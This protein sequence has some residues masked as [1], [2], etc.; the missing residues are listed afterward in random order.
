MKQAALLHLAAA[1]ARR[2][3]RPTSSS[4]EADQRR[5][6]PPDKLII[7]SSR[8]RIVSRS[9]APPTRCARHGVE[10][11]VPHK[12]DAGR[13]SV[14]H[15][16][17]SRPAR[18]T[19]SGR[20]SRRMSII[21]RG[22][23]WQSTVRWTI[24]ASKPARRW[25]DSCCGSH[26]R[27]RAPDLSHFDASTATPRCATTGQYV[28]RDGPHRCD[29][30]ASWGVGLVV[31]A[32]PGADT[33]TAWLPGASRRRLGGQPLAVERDMLTA[34][35]PGLAP[36]LRRRC[37]CTASERRQ[38]SLVAVVERLSREL[39]R[40]VRSLPRSRGARH[41]LALLGADAGTAL[42]ALAPDPSGLWL[43]RPGVTP[44]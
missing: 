22:V 1:G 31:D 17:C 7:T 2:P 15:P 11:L 16:P 37:G 33:T 8:R 6:R 4:P 12:G 38:S 32:R 29:H 5:R 35:S 43:A 3:C 24:G 13:P 40:R 36:L 18:R 10:D 27:R 34:A 9:D 44:T 20:S 23:V 39:S 30:R 14:D 26:R 19:R 21:S 25:P 42:A 41:A 28:D